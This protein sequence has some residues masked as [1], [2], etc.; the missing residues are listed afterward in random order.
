MPAST[1]ALY[2]KAHNNITMMWNC[3]T[4]NELLPKNTFMI[5]RQDGEWYCV[6]E[7]KN[8][9]TLDVIEH[10]VKELVKTMKD[11]EARY[12]SK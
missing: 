8:E 2:K 3:L 6:T 11:H 1:Q 10:L 7:L 4:T 12:A 5:T 9:F